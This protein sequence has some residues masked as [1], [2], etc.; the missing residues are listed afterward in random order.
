[1]TAEKEMHYVAQSNL[2]GAMSAR[3]DTRQAPQQ[4]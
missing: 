1:M 4:I 3:I 2:S